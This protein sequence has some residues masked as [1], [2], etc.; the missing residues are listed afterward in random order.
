MLSVLQSSQIT[1]PQPKPETFNIGL[2]QFQWEP[3]PLYRREVNAIDHRIPQN[4]ENPT[5]TI[6][7]RDINEDE[8]P[9]TISPVPKRT[10]LVANEDTPKGSKMELHAGHSSK[11][12]G[13]KIKNSPCAHRHNSPRSFAPAAVQQKFGLRELW[14]KTSTQ[15]QEKS[16]RGSEKER[17]SNKDTPTQ[18]STTSLLPSQG[19]P[20]N[21]SVSGLQQ[22][23]DISTLNC[24]PMC[25]FH[26]TGT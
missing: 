5:T 24:C 18:N 1:T 15:S 13:K 8:R 4:L 22:N 14:K 9:S 12:G 11:D 10:S 2:E 25:Q 20:A 3:F 7:E 23:E 16:T 26:F 21:S 17:A 19:S 6:A